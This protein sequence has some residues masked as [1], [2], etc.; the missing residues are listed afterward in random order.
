MD[1]TVADRLKQAHHEHPDAVFT[2]FTVSGHVISGRITLSG[3]L[4]TLDA[5]KEMA[6]VPDDRIEAFSMREA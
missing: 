3:K 1:G 4:I 6:V 5:G 2:V